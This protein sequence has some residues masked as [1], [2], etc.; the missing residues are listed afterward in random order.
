[1]EISTENS[2]GETEN[3]GIAFAKAIDKINTQNLAIRQA[4]KEKNEL[5]MLNDLEQDEEKV[6]ELKESLV[7]L[8]LKLKEALE[9]QINTIEMPLPKYYGNV[10]KYDK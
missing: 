8:N 3:I 10:H 2:G 6:K 1:M 5:K 7:A 4:E 9:S